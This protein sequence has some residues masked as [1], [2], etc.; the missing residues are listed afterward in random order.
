M[1]PTWA[2]VKLDHILT[3][4][5]IVKELVAPDVQIMAVVKADA[6]GHGA[7]AIATYLEQHPRRPDW[8]GVALAEEGI[9]LRQAGV[10]SPI[11][12]LG[13]FWQ[14]DQAVDCLNHNLVP[15]IYRLDMLDSLAA[16]AQ[17]ARCK[18]KFHL[19]IDTGMG[20]LGI[21]PSELPALLERLRQTPEL[22]L[23]GVMTHLASADEPEKSAFTQKQ[24]TLFA[25]AQNEIHRQ[26]FQPS[27]YHSANSA[28]TND[29]PQAHGN[30]VRAG[31]L[32]YGFVDTLAP[33]KL[34]AVQPALSLHSRIILLK[35]VPKGEPLGYGNSFH[36]SRESLIAT[37]PIGYED[38]LSRALSNQ[39]RV[40]IRDQ[41]APIVGRVSM[42]L[43]LVDVTDI[44]QVTLGDEAILIGSSNTKKITAEE[45]GVMTN[46]ISYEITCSLT[47]R[48]PRIYYD[49][50]KPYRSPEI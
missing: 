6:Y 35:K 21:L 16:A 4:Y 22:I 46:T 39:G 47:L 28:A 48:V 33:T 49:G 45:I 50:H 20:R 32:L 13:G 7:T 41:F 1:R 25:Q 42:D 2:E 23:D 9:K 10:R 30:M 36:T 5:L 40:I 24:L 44:A 14:Q 19:K 31:G 29:W 17:A 11:L 43:T 27:Y 8:F 15:T 34:P 37:L 12:C 26:G 38:G 3:N 18:A